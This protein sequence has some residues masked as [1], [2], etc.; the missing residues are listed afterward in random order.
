MIL[1]VVKSMPQYSIQQDTLFIV[2]NT[3]LTAAELEVTSVLL[4]WHLWS[5]MQV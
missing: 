4:A 2:N 3:L 5:Q 1:T